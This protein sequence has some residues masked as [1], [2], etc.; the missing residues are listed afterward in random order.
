[1][2]KQISQ[3]PFYSKKKITCT[4]CIKAWCLSIRALV[5]TKSDARCTRK[6]SFFFESDI[7]RYVQCSNTTRIKIENKIGV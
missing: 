3:Y 5:K 1:M 7:R 6:V 2:Y 4:E